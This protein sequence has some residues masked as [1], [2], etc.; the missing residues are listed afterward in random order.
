MDQQEVLE[1]C[2]SQ[3]V[4]LV[5]FIYCDFAGTQRGK[6]A[7]IDDLE[8]RLEYGINM[9]TAH[10]GFTLHDTNVPIEGMLSVG[11]NRLIADLDTFSVLPWMPGH[12]MVCCDFVENDGAPYPACPR[13]WLK[14]IVAR[15][16]ARG[17]R[18]QAAFENEFYLATQDAA[19][20][21]WRPADRG[22]RYVETALDKQGAF[23]ADLTRAVRAMGMTPEMVF[24]E[25]GPGQQEVA[26]RHAEALRAADNQIK[27]RSTIR[28]VALQHGYHA[29]LAAKPFP[30]TYGSGA[31]VHMSL[32][33]AATNTGLMHDPA[34]EGGF[35]LLG[36]QFVAGI[37]R[38]LPALVALTCPSFNSYRRLVPRAWSTSDVCWGYD[39]RSAA[40][41]VPSPY[42]G[43]EQQSQNIE[44]K[45]VDPSCNP[46]V[47]LGGIIAAGLDGI[48]QQLDPGPPLQRDPA[49]LTDDE[50]DRLG[51]RP[52]SRTL[53]EA[54]GEFEADPLFHE[55]MP[56]LLWR[57]YREVK[58]AEC[59]GFE[60]RDDAYELETHFYAF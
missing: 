15:A 60:A 22:G 24:H 11:E 56:D 34:A 4:E 54:V 7:T 57:V 37:L 55:L 5:R 1:L 2:R 10:L 19:T 26:V 33:D 59:D 25:G 14:N 12:A 39:N 23:L 38:H 48:E 8:G 20:G 47:A 40:V 41:R 43:R 49:D 18:V 50:R 13:T 17:L 32:W 52:L 28:G 21:E 35:S 27:L 53:R 31:H 16:A 45:A 29:S 3:S 30:W 58:L 6:V 46:Y 42:R 36:R 9:S 51:I 44:I